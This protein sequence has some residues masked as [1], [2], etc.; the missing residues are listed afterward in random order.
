MADARL[1]LAE[2]P[3]GGSGGRG[4]V[5]SPLPPDDPGNTRCA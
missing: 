1:E 2:A 3:A 5:P 4:L